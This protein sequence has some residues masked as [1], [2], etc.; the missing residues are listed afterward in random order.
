MKIGC[1]IPAAGASRRFG[2]ADKL[3]AEVGGAS[4]V[5]RVA[6]MVVRS[7]TAAC[8]VVVRPDAD[9]VVASLLGLPLSIVE[10][11]LAET[12]MASSISAGIA[13]LDESID[14]AFVL[15]AD[16]PA[17]TSAFL[18]QMIAGFA[19]DG[20]KRVVVPVTAEGGQRNPVLWPRAYFRALMELEGDGGAKGLVRLLPDE[21]VRLETGESS[22]FADVDTLE[23]LADLGRLG[24]H[25]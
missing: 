6:G 19:A 3:T 21:A 24:R 7:Q 16:M 13:A 18:D 17:M 4:M 25:S 23:D 12:G 14:G 9:E 8:L 20:G 15:P 10:N 2:A 22:L 1:V 11:P 5:R